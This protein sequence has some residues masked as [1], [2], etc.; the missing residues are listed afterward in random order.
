MYAASDE[1]PSP[2]RK[3]RLLRDVE[4]L[5]AAIRSTERLIEASAIG[6]DGS[7]G[8]EEPTLPGIA[9]DATAL[10]TG[11]ERMRGAG[12]AAAAAETSG[13]SPFVVDRFRALTEEVASLKEQLAD[14]DAELE[15][16]HKLLEAERARFAGAVDEMLQ[17]SAELARD[18][19]ELARATAES[20]DLA[21]RARNRDLEAQLATA[22]EQLAAER[23]QVHLLK[24]RVDV[25][26]KRSPRQI[27]PAVLRAV[28]VL[29]DGARGSRS[30]IS[31][32]GSVASHESTRGSEAGDATSTAALRQ[33]LRSVQDQNAAAMRA[34]KAE[35]SRL[36]EQL[37]GAG[38][39]ASA[40]APVG[41][42]QSGVSHGIGGPET[43]A[44][45]LVRPSPTM[46]SPRP[47][48]GRG[49]RAAAY[50]PR[51]LQR[52]ATP[53]K[54]AASQPSAEREG[55]APHTGE[56]GRVPPPPPPP[57]APSG[58]ADQANGPG[59][60]IAA[61]FK[62]SG[63]GDT[64]V[65]RDAAELNAAAA[66]VEVEPGTTLA[67]LLGDDLDRLLYSEGGK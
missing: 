65:T 2:L 30:P 58:E 3:A 34:L 12:A 39:A 37:R 38:G 48:R 24:N 25:M 40:A 32:G 47:G 52:P 51:P 20:G 13:M 35:N 44:S 62:T 15:E 56:G 60:D 11:S 22:N 27:P 49:G 29:K 17:E 10:A 55:V 61:A 23:R 18:M 64:A 59:F 46:R 50:T 41:S 14:R 53:A 54:G 42:A 21:L 31:P 1:L 28:G 67:S 7:E 26:E 45:P 33:Q 19:E 4:D 57:A 43:R 66:A 6:G 63:G 9:G 5:D 36:R 8:V 16:V